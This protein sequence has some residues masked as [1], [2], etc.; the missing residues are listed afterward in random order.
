MIEAAQSAGLR[1][2]GGDVL[3]R[4]GESIAYTHDNWYSQ[5]AGTEG[6]EAFSARSCDY[7]RNYVTSYGH[8]DDD[9]LLFV[10]VVA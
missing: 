6:S 9:S 8:A 1:V 4:S 2:L 7:A 5:S 10:V 3:R